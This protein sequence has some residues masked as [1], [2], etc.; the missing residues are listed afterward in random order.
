[1]KYQDSPNYH[2]MQAFTFTVSFSQHVMYHLSFTLLY[3]IR[4]MGGWQLSLQ[5]TIQEASKHAV[6]FIVARITNED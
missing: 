5:P 2:K 6:Y 1:M 4:N 3:G